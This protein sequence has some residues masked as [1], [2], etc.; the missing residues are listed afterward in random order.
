M[1]IH[2]YK[3]NIIYYTPNT[4]KLNVDKQIFPKNGDVQITIFSTFIGV[5]NVK[6]LVMAGNLLYTI[7]IL[8][9]DK[10]KTKM[11]NQILFYKSVKNILL[12]N[13]KQKC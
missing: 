6:L 11:I 12:S 10:L 13:K 1:V 7:F 3:A 2:L 8:I 4:S 9:K 5:N